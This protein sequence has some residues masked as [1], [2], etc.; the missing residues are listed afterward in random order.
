MLPV[1]ITVAVGARSVPVDDVKDARVA[2][3]FR[4]AG[5]DVGRKL[6]TITCP[7]HAK[8]A[9]NVRIHFDARGNANLQY[10]SCCAELGV[11]VG[12]ALG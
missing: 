12:R 11:A 8:T 9:G 10:D 5:Q 6:A 4:A 1:R 3:A 2:S 7:V